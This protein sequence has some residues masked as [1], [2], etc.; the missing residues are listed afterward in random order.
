MR[1]VGPNLGPVRRSL[2]P[3]RLIF[4]V[5]G[6]VNLIGEHIDY[7]GLAVLPMAV[8]RTLRIEA[9]PRNDS[10]I[11][12]T[13]TAGFERREFEWTPQIPPFASGD[14]GNYVKA[15]AQAIGDHWGVQRGIDMAVDSNIPS[16]A[17][18]SSSSALLTGVTL[19][20]LSAAGIET[21][22]EE[23]MQ[24]LP[25]GEHYVGT[26]GGG[27]DHAAC[28]AGQPGAAVLVEFNPVSATPIPL[29]GDWAFLV[30]HSLH[31]AEKSGAAREQYNNRSRAA[32]AA[33]AGSV[34]SPEEA[35]AL[36]HI[37]SEAAR[38][39]HAI[40]AIRG[41]DVPA[42][43][44][45]LNESHRSLRDVL[46]VS[47]PQADEVVEACLRAG[48]LGARITGAGFGGYVLAFCLRNQLAGIMAEIERDYYSQ[49]PARAE[50]GEYLMQVQPSAGALI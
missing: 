25:D 40:A 8:D 14:W 27:M 6:R 32:R 44:T 12:A 22:F 26:R 33:L 3:G 38:V 1:V 34:S 2:R 36:Q 35:N 28:L 9:T 41:G 24:I 47:C 5:P 4:H 37:R 39:Q 46:Q 48:A 45:V 10:R 43:A 19:A 50:F 15:A 31:R 17:G 29:P 18:L 20:L 13:S 23:L 7:A 42:F 30:A 49:Q 16:A 11:C 21:T